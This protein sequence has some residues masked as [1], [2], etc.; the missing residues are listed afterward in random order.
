MLIDL[1]QKLVRS[2]FWRLGMESRSIELESCVLHYFEYPHP[3]PRGTIVLVHGLGTSSST[4]LKILPILIKNH[5]VIALDL[6]GF[7]FSDL[8]PGKSFCTMSEHRAALSTLVE[9]VTQSPFTLVGQSFGGW[10]SVRYAAEH[11]RRITRLIL[12]NTAGIYYRGVEDLRELF[13][14]ETTADMRRLLDALWYR[15]PWYFK[16]FTTAIFRDLS[17]R[18][19]SD[20]VASIDAKDFLVEELAQLRL[21]VSVIWG[22]DDNVISSASVDVIKKF[23]PGSN[24]YLISRCGHVPQLERPEEVKRIFTS[25]LTQG[26]HGL[27]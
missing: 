4:W 19:I 7:G 20:I 15:Y 24:V 1:V 8:K 27:D 13:A 11:P 16:P 21:P 6:P 25:I 18:N 23:V 14:I 22:K 5:R 17:Q 26:V 2:A 12:I 10:L 9:H 3:T